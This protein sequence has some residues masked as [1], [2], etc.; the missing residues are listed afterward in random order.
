[1]KIQYEHDLSNY[2]Y[3][4]SDFNVIDIRIHLRILTEFNENLRHFNITDMSSFCQKEFS[5]SIICLNKFIKWHKP[6]FC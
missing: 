5:M 4:F 6:I 1:M 2:M 3:L